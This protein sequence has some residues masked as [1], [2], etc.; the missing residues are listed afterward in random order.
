MGRFYW[1]LSKGFK[2][3]LSGIDAILSVSWTFIG[4]IRKRFYSLRCLGKYNNCGFSPIIFYCK[5]FFIESFKFS[6][7]MIT[8]NPKHLTKKCF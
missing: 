1:C 5:R 8:L 4:N 3:Y 2:L 6:Q 7:I